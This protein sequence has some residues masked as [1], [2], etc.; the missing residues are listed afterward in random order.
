MW[1]DS[2]KKYILVITPSNIIVGGVCLYFREGLANSRRVDFELFQEMVVAE[3][4]IARKK[5]IFSVIYRSPSQ[6]SE[7]ISGLF[8]YVYF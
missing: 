8:I 7:E 3:I 6:S 1:R 2:A 4:D 5:V